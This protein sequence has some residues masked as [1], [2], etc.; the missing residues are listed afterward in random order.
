MG[1]I[2]LIR[3][4]QEVSEQMSRL[5]ATGQKYKAGTRTLELP[6]YKELVKRLNA[7][8]EA[9]AADSA[10]LMPATRVALFDGR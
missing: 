1:R 6:E 4:R 8:D 7:I 10:G 2:D 5:Y 9:L 3:E